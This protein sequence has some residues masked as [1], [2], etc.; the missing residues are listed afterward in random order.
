MD[1]EVGASLSGMKLT[2][3]YV[4]TCGVI[5]GVTAKATGILKDQRLATLFLKVNSDVRIT[6]P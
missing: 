3:D 4:V 2:G 1:E 6:G 5:W